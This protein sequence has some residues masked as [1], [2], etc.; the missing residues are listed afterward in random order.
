VRAVHVLIPLLAACGGD[1]SI[2]EVPN[3]EPT[4]SV[5]SPPNGSEY[6]EGTLVAFAAMVDDDRDANDELYLLWQS[7]IDGV[8]E[9]GATGQADGT[10]TFVTANLT[11][12]NHAISLT[13]VDSDAAEASDVVELTIIDVPDAPEVT[14]LHPITGEYGVEGEQ[15]EFEAI[16]SDEQDEPEDLL[17]YIASDHEAV[18]GDFCEVTPDAAGMVSCLYALPAGDHFLEFEAVD[19]DG[20]SGLATVYLEVISADAVDDDGD[21]WSENQG[22]CDDADPSVHPTA[23]EFYN[24][25]D[26]DCD[27]IVDDGTVGYDD[28]GDTWTE[29]DGDCDDDDADSYPDAEEQCD[30]ADNDCDEVIDEDTVCF[31]DD[32]DCYCEG[33]SCD[34]SIYDGCDSLGTGDCDDADPSA[35][36]DGVEVA[37]AV[38]NDCDGTVDEGT[39]AFDDDGDCYCESGPCQGSVD[40]TC[41]SVVDGDCDDTSDDINPGADEQCDG[42]DND[43]DSGIDEADA[44]DASTWYPDTDADSYGDGSLPSVACTQPSGSVA[45]SSDCDDADATINPAVT[46]YCNGYD[47]D[48]DGTTDESDAA[49][50][51][52][53]FD[54]AD[55]D[56]YGWVYTTV[57]QC[58]AP[59]GYV[60]DSSDCDDASS[61]TYPGATEYCDGHDDDCDGSTDESDAADA[62]TWY[63]DDDGDGY[64]DASSPSV[65]CY[66]PSGY[67]ADSTDCDDLNATSYPGATEYCDGHD[68]DC[69]GSTDESDAADASTWYAD[70][71][72]DGYGNPSSYSVGCYQPASYV[73]NNT[74][75]NDGDAGLNPA[76]YWY[77]DSD[78]DGY[79]SSSYW[80]QQCTQPSGYVSNASDCNDGRSSSYPGATEYCN[81]YDDDCDG[82]T[83]ESS[84]VD[85]STWYIDI[86]GDGYGGSG[87]ATACSQ[88]TSY[89]ANSSDCYDSN[90]YANPAATSY[91]AS[92]R[93]DGSYDYNCDGSSSKY[94]TTTY[95]CNVHWSGFSC[96]GY[97]NGWSGSSPSCGSTGSYRT[98]C[99]AS[100]WSCSYSSSSTTYQYCR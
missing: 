12:G 99:S 42:I 47:D 86:D 39:T 7:D 17:V 59:S 52:T 29:L 92:H 58:V 64:G 80:T 89:V 78:S 66:A 96:D 57:V 13:A 93:G 88:P 36:P 94:Y 23:E 50:V 9:E 63:A 72:G 87:S 28:D 49:D 79:G 51:S 43:C 35:N 32:G 73:S 46:E 2:V 45:D 100:V 77:Q 54:D 1:T 14:I 56:G 81:G 16:V 98:G 53:W 48:C 27:G 83:D 67:V 69:D 30:G 55:S 62:S 71:D 25:V 15:Y 70:G 74:D 10:V 6:D 76:T 61:S 31:D 34:G 24:E 97:T 41:G 20:Y 85:A 3:T 82:Y 38:D 5:T 44:I 4:V 84:S 19:L 18:D 65:Q 91:Y 90:A 60:A 40:A 22:D 33:G 75:C 37:D 11:P 26:D 21:G 68:D 95:S 8:L